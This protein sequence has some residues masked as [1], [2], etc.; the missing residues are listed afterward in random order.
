VDREQLR[1]VVE[2]LLF[3]SDSP[4]S[5][6]LLAETT[7]QDPSDLAE[8]LED[9]RLKYDESG[10]GMRVTEMAGGYI[11]ITREEHAPWIRS[12]MRGKRKSRLSRASLEALAIIAYKQPVTRPEIEEI[13]GVDSGSALA[14]LLE[15]DM[16]TIRGRADVVGRPLLYA[17]TGEFLTYFGLRELTELPRPEELKALIQSREASED[18]LDE[19]DEVS[20]PE[21]LVDETGVEAAAVE[22]ASPETDVKDGAAEV[23]QSETSPQAKESV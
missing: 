22:E 6:S 8:A 7:G 19:G 12:L 4:L 15:R 16:V 20:V 18:E 5:L 1:L 9:L 2:A 13:R 14:T 23:E 10:H 11:I 17:T 3:A 21:A